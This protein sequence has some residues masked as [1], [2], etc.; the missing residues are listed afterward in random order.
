MGELHP[1]DKVLYDTLCSE[2]LSKDDTQA[3]ATKPK[4][5]PSGTRINLGLPGGPVFKSDK[6]VDEEDARFVAVT[7]NGVTYF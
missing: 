7:S 1:E 6:S 3:E 4:E 2:L 5:M